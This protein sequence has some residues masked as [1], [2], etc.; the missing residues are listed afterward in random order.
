MNIFNALSFFLKLAENTPVEQDFE[1]NRF[2]YIEIIKKIVK[3]FNYAQSD[4][5]PSRI[6]NQLRSLIEF[7]KSIDSLVVDTDPSGNTI[8][9]NKTIPLSRYIKKIFS[10][11]LYDGTFQEQWA[12]DW[13]ISVVV[14]IAKDK[15]K[16]DDL[17]FPFFETEKNRD[18]LYDVFEEAVYSFRTQVNAIKYA[19]LQTTEQ[20]NSYET[21]P[22]GSKD[23]SLVEF[24][25]NKTS[26]LEQKNRHKTT[27]GSYIRRHLNISSK[28]VPDNAVAAI[29]NIYSSSVSLHKDFEKDLDKLSGEDIISAYKKHGEQPIKIDSCMAGSKS[30]NVVM[31]ALNP[32]KVKLLVYRDIGTVVSEKQ[33][34][35]GARVY[36]DFARALL[37]TC[38]DGTLVLD[39]VYPSG[40]KYVALLRYWAMKNGIILRRNPDSLVSGDVD[41]D[42]G[43]TKHI[44]MKHS[45]V[46]PYLD[47]FKFGESKSGSINDKGVIVLCNKQEDEAEYLFE[48]TGGGYD[49]IS[50]LY[51]ESC[52][53]RIDSDDSN[54]VEGSYYCNSCY[55]ER[56]FNCRGCY[57]NISRDDWGGE[58]NGYDYCNDCFSDKFA[59]CD[60]CG[61]TATLDDTTVLDDGTPVCESCYS[62]N[63]FTCYECDTVGI[64]NDDL[65]GEYNNKKYCT[66][67]F[68]KKFIICDSCGDSESRDESLLLKDGTIYCDYCKDEALKCPICEE[69]YQKNKSEKIN[70]LPAI[71]LNKQQEFFVCKDCAEK[72]NKCNECSSK[73]SYRLRE[74]LCAKCAPGLY[75]GQLSLPIS[76]KDINI[77][78]KIKETDFN[79][80]D[81]E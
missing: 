55:E 3:S 59:V 32:D 6:T 51:C 37:W 31:Y 45:G 69:F 66:D 10:K 25:R 14:R 26:K 28:E 41:L 75:S 30:R 74:G 70:S 12:Y 5:Y 15:I 38:D 53:D 4:T 81:L 36:Q 61:E 2:L 60:K 11:V 76:E 57:D 48:T 56:F 35:G 67:C 54:Y 8:Y 9:P 78:K 29:V 72:Y 40:S 71:S 23:Y 49:V 13:F 20:D 58:Y 52:N 65:G 47:T 62:D 24:N 68:N 73:V 33:G 44:T 17:E 19:L 79:N 42:D 64:D 18:I 16:K 80:D 77:N 39:R 27:L 50:E 21:V 46:F 1:A 22:L 63:Y 7:G 43:S 34:E